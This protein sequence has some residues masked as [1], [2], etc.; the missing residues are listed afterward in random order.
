MTLQHVINEQNIHH[1]NMH[2]LLIVCADLIYSMLPLKFI[3]TTVH[4]TTALC[5]FT[6]NYIC[7]CLM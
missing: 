1:V 7:N 3:I 2:Q 5:H 6:V 4:E